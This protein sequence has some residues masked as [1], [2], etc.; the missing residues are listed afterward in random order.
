MNRRTILL[1][2]SVTLVSKLFSKT[3]TTLTPA[4]DATVVLEVEKT[5][6]M[7]GK[8]HRF[9]FAD[10]HGHVSDGAPGVGG[11]QVIFTVHSASIRCEDTWVN[12]KDRSKILKY[13][14]NDMLKAD[15]Y[16]EIRYVSSAIHE[17]GGNSYSIDGNLTIGIKTRPVSVCAARQLDGAAKPWWNG[18]AVISLSDF[19]LRA[20]TAALGA[21][22]TKDKMHL[23][24]HLIAL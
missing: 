4:A 21:I 22:G 3:L 11:K 5:G 2:G 14:L 10:Y 9:V 12:D 1:L 8:K 19:G 18:S 13:A 7:A 20:P 24:F 23:S 16:P 17:R 15:Q 6:L